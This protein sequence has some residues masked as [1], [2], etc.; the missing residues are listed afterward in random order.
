[1]SKNI[2]ICCDGTG[3]EVEGN[4]SNVLKLFRI[5]EKSATQRVYYHPG[6]GTIGSRDNWTR[7]KQDTWAVFGLAT[8]YGLDADTLAAYRF[9]C[10][11]YE[12]GDSIF[13]FGFSRGA[14]TMRV[15][16]GFIHMVGLLPPDQADVTSYALTA[17]KRS[18]QVG[19]LKIAWDFSRVIG[20]RRVP[21]KFVGCWDTVASVI[22]PR[23][24]RLYIPTLQMLPYTRTNPSV[25]AFRHAMAIDEKRRMFRLNRW[26]PGQ[27]FVADPFGSE[28]DGV[29]Q[30]IKQVWFA[31]VHSDVGGGYPEDQSAA[32]KFPLKWMID[33]AVVH[34][35]KI[36]EAM[37]AHLVDGEPL[38][39]GRR[40]YVEPSATADL[41]DSMPPAWRI[42]EYF[43]KSMKW[44]EWP[45]KEFLSHYI[46]N[47]EPRSLVRDDTKP[48]LHQSVVD[49]RDQVPNYRPVNWPAD[50]D[51]EPY[52][53]AADPTPQQPV[54]AIA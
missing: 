37:R 4:L 21:I 2:V 50:F 29:P 11:R 14:Y 31:G 8:G 25:M 23:P 44:N 43:P 22:V 27:N 18:G 41:H 46:P 49:R 30:D 17:Y 52:H 48:L 38:G 35:L 39:D 3:N 16:A 6:I 19:E 28:R 47:A 54:Q 53:R 32:S 7:W 20:G 36:N 42:L 10:D 13:L 40:M 9:I 5:A 33:E 51:I 1:V 26:T 15:L 24:D 34:G 45:R 12:D